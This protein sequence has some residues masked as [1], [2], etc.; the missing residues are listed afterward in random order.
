M[1]SSALAPQNTLV[2]VN[3]RRL[4]MRE[5]TEDQQQLAYRFAA[6]ALRADATGCDPWEWHGDLD[7]RR[8][9]VTREWDVGGVWV[10]VGGEQSHRGHLTRW[11]HVGGEDQCDGADRHQLIQALTDAG[12]LL[13]GLQA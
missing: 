2:G 3:Q 9:F 10:S 11:L 6:L 12:E 8:Y 1:T 7:W 5:L 13:E 4:T